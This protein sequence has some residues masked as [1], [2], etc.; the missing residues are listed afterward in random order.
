[1]SVVCVP[2][3]VL[4]EVTPQLLSLATEQFYTPVLSGQSCKQAKLIS[5][6]TLEACQ[7]AAVSL[8]LTSPH[9]VVISNASRPKG[10][11]KNVLGEPQFNN[12][13]GT[14]SKGLEWQDAAICATQA[15]MQA[16]LLLDLSAEEFNF[17]LEFL[18]GASAV[19]PNWFQ[20]TFASPGVNRQAPG[21]MRNAM[22]GGVLGAALVV[23]RSGDDLSLFLGGSFMFGKFL[24]PVDIMLQVARDSG[25]WEFAVG[26]ALPAF[27]LY[28]VHLSS[29]TPT[30]M[31]FGFG[32]LLLSTFT[33]PITWMNATVADGLVIAASLPMDSGPLAGFG[34]QA[35]IDDL[36]VVVSVGFKTQSVSIKVELDVQWYIMK[37]TSKVTNGDF[38]LNAGPQVPGGFELGVGVT[39][40]VTQH[41]SPVPVVFT[42]DILVGADTL[43]F[44][45]Q[46]LTPWN[47][48][49]GIT[50]LALL[51]CELLFDISFEGVPTEFGFQASLT[52]GAPGPSQIKGSIAVLVDVLDPTA[53]VLAGNISSLSLG[54]LFGSMTSS[55]S[56]L[57]SALDSCSLDALSLS[58]VPG[59]N[60]VTFGT[61]TYP[62][63]VHFSIGHFNF[64]SM[65]GSGVLAVSDSSIYVNVEIEPFEKLGGLL[66]VSG[67][68]LASG[69]MLTLIVQAG[70]GNE[71]FEFSAAAQFLG[72]GASL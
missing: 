39:I 18:P 11:L 26:I 27:T 19:T 59:V 48:A 24:E 4:R 29:S 43:G 50:N 9:V 44:Q 62:A 67:A 69:N 7:A 51:N 6:S 70:G 54:D 45:A 25:S 55:S 15:P 53:S 60:S 46:L 16:S 57:Q 10:C 71:F 28:Q 35:G 13:T 22:H 40:A 2:G 66:Q 64:G 41:G 1:M 8:K 52:I 49:F 36:E 65:H 23:K 33:T 68:P 17:S 47:H 37:P 12:F 31:K 34:R 63:G 56:S 42:S 58:V 32:T 14:L 61:T 21:S 5:V 3:Y 38:F 30:Y 20:N 72:F